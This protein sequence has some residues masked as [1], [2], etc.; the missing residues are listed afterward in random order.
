MHKHQPQ[1]T[2]QNSQ[3][4]AH[5]TPTNR[6]GETVHLKVGE[7]DDVFQRQTD[8]VLQRVISPN[9]IQKKHNP[10]QVREQ[11]TIQLK[12]NPEQPNKELKDTKVQTKLYVSQPGDPHEQEAD[13]MADKVMSMGELESN[14][15]NFTRLGDQ[16]SRKEQV[17][18]TPLKAPSENVMRK[19]EGGTN[20]TVMPTP[21]DK[22]KE[23]VQP[24]EEKVQNTELKDLKTAQEAGNE[25]PPKT[26]IALENG[27]GSGHP[28]P[29]KTRK[30]MERRFQVDFSKVRIHNDGLSAELNKS[31]HAKAFTFRNHIYF[32]TGQFQ[33][34]SKEGQY[35]LAHELT[36]IIQQSGGRVN[37]SRQ[38]GNIIQAKN[39]PG[40]AAS[41]SGGGSGS[42]GA[43]KGSSNTPASGT[44]K[45][46]GTPPAQSGAT[47]SPPAQG[48][49]GS[50]KGTDG[51][52]MPEPPN[53]LSD[54]EQ[55][56]LDTVKN[57]ASKVADKQG[58]LPDADT[59]VSGAR[60]A[61]NEPKTE[62]DARAGK[63]VVTALKQKAPPSPEIKKLCEDIR[64][65]IKDKRPPDENSL[66]K[67]DPTA[68]AKQAGNQIDGS[69][70]N[71]ADKAQ[72]NYDQLS[73]TPTGAAPQKGQPIDAP[74]Q[75]V[76]TAP[77]GAQ[78]AVP[79]GVPEQNVSLNADVASG[80][81]QIQD[82]GMNT[83]PAK[84]VKN[85]PIADARG[86]QGELAQAAKED[87]AKVMAEQQ[88]ALTK[89]NTDML[90]L[91][92]SA[93]AA[94]SGSRAGG[95][96]GVT[97]RQGK[98]VETE[99]QTR[100]RVGKE[101][102]TI[103]ESAQKKVTELL[104]PLPESGMN[105]WEAGVKISSEKFKNR[106][107][108]VEDWIKERHSGGWGAVVEFV[109]D[110]TGLP[111][112]VTQEYNAAE[113]EF[114]DEACTLIE[115]IS[116]DV[117]T[118]IASCERI[119]E[120]ARK[121]IDKLFSDLPANLKDWAKGEQAR[122]SEQLNQLQGQVTKTR[123]DFNKDLAD[124]A[125]TAVQEVR[126]QVHALREKA[127]GMIGR[128]KDA[129]DRFLA[130]PA[131][132]ILEGLLELVGIPPASFW[133][134]IAK[135]KKV[136]KD[137]AAN[138]MG[139]ANNLMKA[140]G[141]GFQQFFDNFGKHLLQGFLDWLLSGMK[142]VGVTIPKDLSLKSVITFFLQLMG[143]TWARI[144]KLLVKHIGEKNVG[145]IEKAF[146]VVAKLIELGPKGLF[147]LLESYLD[148]NKIMKTV[149]DAGIKFLIEA[150]IKQVTARIILLFNPVGAIAQAVEAIYRVL[151]WVFQNAAR[152]FTLIET[153]V[154][155][156]ADLIA[157]NFA[158]MANAV[159][160]GLAKLIPPVI[161]FLADY[162]GL[163][164]LP[165]KIADVVRGL[166]EWVEGM[167]DKVI[168]WMVVQG[169]KLLAAVGLGGK[170]KDKKGGKYDGQIG[171][172]V[173]FTAAK[174]SHKLWIVEKGGK[175][176]VMMASVEK[177]LLEQLNED[178][179]KANEISDQTTRD[180]IIGL[181]KNAREMH[182]DLKSKADKVVVDAKKSKEKPE[183]VTPE[184]VAS[185]DDAV[186]NSQD[187][188]TPKLQEILNKISENL[189]GP[190]PI[191]GEHQVKDTQSKVDR[192]SH[193]VPGKALVFTLKKEIEELL[194]GLK[195]PTF[196]DIE[197][198]QEFASKLEAYLYGYIGSINKNGDKL[199]AI[200]LSIESHR[201]GGDSPIHSK[202]SINDIK[203]ELDKE[204]Q[205]MTREFVRVRTKVSRELSVNPRQSTWR[206]FLA[207]SYQAY[208][209]KPNLTPDNIGIAKSLISSLESQ[210]NSEVVSNSRAFSLLKSNLRNT[211]KNAIEDAY[212]QGTTSVNIAL[213]ASK[214]DGRP[215]EQTSA[216]S[217]LE[218]LYHKT[219]G[220]IYK[221]KL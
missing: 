80:E 71:N 82:A 104:K 43:Q 113:K 143:I 68:A 81:K 25:V 40:S 70:K 147:D 96:T 145:L 45:S 149:I 136:I 196:N 162:I 176:V 69:I 133:A 85:G 30:F 32:N 141:Q 205:K 129:L 29:V 220:D 89:A 53:K 167:L 111:A 6:D 170:D 200:L 10:S 189:Y 179:T 94:L 131:K 150:L 26:R 36:H 177:P 63:D 102:T 191:A 161:G 83:D 44:G 100:T 93:M 157:G 124:R 90:A 216:L 77:P 58:A 118:V 151:K 217:S 28:L 206:L 92:Q 134:L 164:D 23:T 11:E 214:K 213:K 195:S 1:P 88:A 84:L 181:I 142:S 52:I 144:R 3:A 192:E 159:E 148:P 120:D 125:S 114:G 119:I 51:V 74:P 56:R 103:F 14:P 123:D 127:K 140:I 60:A 139:F 128:L 202:K 182:L 215:K 31:L 91:Q 107:K 160:K 67:A 184:Q 39:A 18:E 27:K 87:P 153:I 9:A 126:E 172:V 105:K 190:P 165:N 166:Q 21:Q 198:A 168:E 15:M 207:E 174:E 194:L 66:V 218:S 101:A 108:K 154:N 78:T 64:K 8:Q 98:M 72:S 186:E 59:N 212:I 95:V 48:G 193:H 7:K 117:N 112:W 19:D 115:E 16:I 203:L 155:G 34:D 38:A 12:E 152:I 185:E 79:S 20:K 109:D 122:F 54:A 2:Q 73:E 42:G 187:S 49:A 47:G 41:K 75:S 171:K 33:P 204:A 76:N 24:K 13:K 17:V 156:I 210:I 137:I 37:I 183:E 86:A 211:I 188:I 178:E 173:N 219:W 180:E 138:P 62:T 208:T 221:I 97:K 61:V 158:A 116:S 57:N 35:L 130:D 50:K 4:A 199:S 46:P 209:K 146:S 121:Q 135:I 106:L 169:K 175:A 132:F 201:K 99:E 55:K 163:G 197:P 65:A 22:S 5:V 110:I